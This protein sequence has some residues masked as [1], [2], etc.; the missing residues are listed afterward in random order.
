MRVDPTDGQ[1]VCK[2]GD[3]SLIRREDLEHW[4]QA[5]DDWELALSDPL[6]A[7]LPR[8]ATCL[9]HARLTAIGTLHIATSFDDRGKPVKPHI[10][11]PGTTRAKEWPAAEKCM[12]A[13]FNEIHFE[14]PPEFV[15][16][17]VEMDLDVGERPRVEH[18]SVR[19]SLRK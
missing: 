1:P 3:G 17:Q 8:F 2:F 13:A 5:K 10:E 12:L 9:E 18:F 16:P 7:A 19:W 15:A 4:A 6:T 14:K 11:P